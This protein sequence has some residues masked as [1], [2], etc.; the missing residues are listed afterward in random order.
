MVTV[1]SKLLVTSSLRGLNEINHGK[2]G[3]KDLEGLANT[4]GLYF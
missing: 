1:S 2:G 4:W 3:C